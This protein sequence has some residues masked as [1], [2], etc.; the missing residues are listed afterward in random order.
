MRVLRVIGP[1]LAVICLGACGGGGGTASG[2]DRLSA[3]EFREQADAICAE[4]E[5]QLDALGAPTSLN[6][7]EDFVA[8]AVP[9]LE[10]GNAELNRLRPPEELEEQWNRALEINND[11]LATV[12]DL[13]EAV[14]E[15]DQG[16]MQELLQQG[17]EASA[18]ADRL[19]AEMG[20]EQCGNQ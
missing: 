5:G 1:L 6:D 16:R 19:A 14:A 8:K 4:Y 17:N 2:G 15:G 20:L 3:A 9:I 12:R 11:Q 10:E 13:E 18:E 7:L